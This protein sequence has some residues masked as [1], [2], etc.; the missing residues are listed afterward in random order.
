VA[1]APGE[2]AWANAPADKNSAARTVLEGL[3]PP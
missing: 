2:E 3:T 1:P